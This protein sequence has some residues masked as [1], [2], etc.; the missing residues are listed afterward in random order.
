MATALLRFEQGATLGFAGEAFI[1]TAGSLV[2]VRNSNNTG[3]VS[4]TLELLYGPPGSTFEI[5]PS[6][7]AVVAS[8]SNA[9]P[10][11]TFTPQPGFPGCYRFRLTV[12]AADGSSDVDI[13]NVV[14]LTS[15]GILIPP[16]QAL[17]APLPLTGLG[18]KPDELNV[19]GQAWGWAGDEV[20]GVNRNLAILESTVGSLSRLEVTH[21]G[22]LGNEGLRA[23]VGV[24][25]GQLALVRGYNTAGDGVGA[26]LF[27]WRTTSAAND[28]GLRIVPGAAYGSNM[29]GAH[30]ERVVDGSELN[31]RWFGAAGDASWA[32]NTGGVN[33]DAGIQRA[34][35]VV[36]A[37]SAVPNS[38]PVP[39]LYFPTG[40]Y[41][42]T[43]TIQLRS[44]VSIRGDGP[45]SILFAPS[46]ASLTRVIQIGIPGSPPA[47][48]FGAVLKDISILGFATS[49]VECLAMSACDIDFYADGNFN[50]LFYSY[51]DPGLASPS[52]GDGNPS[53]AVESSVIRIRRTGFDA[54][55][56]TGWP[57][58][59]GFYVRGWVNGC[60]VYVDLTYPK[61]AGIYYESTYGSGTSRFSGL[62][63]GAGIDI[64]GNG[65]GDGY[66]A[67]IIGS[68]GIIVEN[69][70]TEGCK[71][72]V[73][74]EG[75]RETI[76]RNVQ[77]DVFCVGAIRPTIEN[78]LGYV[79][80]DDATIEPVVNNARSSNVS[81][82]PVVRATVGAVSL[83][84]SDVVGY[85][86]DLP[87]FSQLD[88]VNLVLNGDFERFTAADGQP[89]NCWGFG[90]QYLGTKCGDGCADTTR[91]ANAAH[92]LKLEFYPS[93][94][95]LAQALVLPAGS[96]SELLGTRLTVS[97]KI[98]KASANDAY[99]GIARADDLSF[100]D[101]GAASA[102]GFD[103]ENG[104]K[105]FVGSWTITQE[106]LTH[107]VLVRLSIASLTDVAYFS[108][109]QVVLGNAA[110]RGFIKPSASI[111]GSHRRVGSAIMTNANAPPATSWNGLA[112]IA[113][114]L[115]LNTG[116]SSMV[117]WRYDGD[118]WEPI[119]EIVVST[120]ADLRTLSTTGLAT[121]T[122]ARAAGYWAAGDGGGGLFRFSTSSATNNDGVVVVSGSAHGSSTSGAHW[123]RLIDSSL[124]SVRWFGARGDDAADDGTAIART[125]AAAVPLGLATF[126]PA[127]Q[128]RVT[129]S[130]DISD[131]AAATRAGTRIVGTQ[132]G[133]DGGDVSCRIIWRGPT[134]DPVI[135]AWSRGVDI[136]NISIVAITA[137]PAC[138][139]I[140]RSP[141]VG[142]NAVTN[143][144]VEQVRFECR[145]IA[146]RGIRI[147][148]LSVGNL[149]HNRF[150]DCYFDGFTVAGIDIVS[151]TGQSKGNVIQSCA[152][153]GHQASRPAA[154]KTLTGS[155]QM[156]DCQWQA[157]GTALDLGSPTDVIVVDGVDAE[158]CRRLLN[159][160]QSG[161]AWSVTVRNTR[162]SLNG[163]HPDNRVIRYRSRGPFL[164]ESV[165]FDISGPP[166]DAA[167]RIW[168]GHDDSAQPTVFT[169]RNCVFSNLTPIEIAANAIVVGQGSIGWDGTS[170][171]VSLNMN[172]D[173]RA[174]G[175]VGNG[176]VTD[177]AA[178][179]GA[180]A[181]PLVS[182][183]VV[184]PG[185][186]L[187]G[188]M[189]ISKPVRFERGA[190][191][192]IAA[193]A[194][195]TFTGTLSLPDSHCIDV[196]ASG[197]DIRL[198][199]ATP[200]VRPEWFGAVG[201]GVADDAVALRRAID[202]SV[203][204]VIGSTTGAGTWPKIPVLVSRHHRLASEIKLARYGIRI[205][206]DQ[207][208]PSFGYTFEVTK[209][210]FTIDHSGNGFRITEDGMGNPWNISVEDLIVQRSAGFSGQGSGIAFD[211][212]G[213]L[214][215][216]RFH[217]LTLWSHSRGL[218]ILASYTGG[219]VANVDLDNF[220]IAFN[221]VGVHSED[222]C[223]FNMLRIGAGVLSDNSEGGFKAPILIADI[224]GPVLA[225][226]Q[227][228]PIRITGGTTVWSRLGTIY[229]EQPGGGYDGGDALISLSAAIKVKV[230]NPAPSAGITSL[231]EVLA[232]SS[233]EIEYSGFMTAYDVA[234]SKFKGFALV[235]TG[236]DV[237]WKYFQFASWPL[238]LGPGPSMSP[239][240]IDAALETVTVFTS[241]H[242]ILTS[243]RGEEVLAATIGTSGA[244]TNLFQTNVELATW[245]PGQWLAI[246]FAIRYDEGAPL[247]AVNAQFEVFGVDPGNP[248]IATGQVYSAQYKPGTIVIWALVRNHTATTFSGAQVR[249]R[250]YG[251]TLG[252]V[253]YGALISPLVVVRLAS[254]TTR[255]PAVD[256]F[257]LMLK[258]QNPRHHDVRDF[259]A[260]VD[261]S[262]N[263]T[264]ALVSAMTRASTTK[265]PV[266]VPAG[267]MRVAGF[268]VPAGVR[269]VGEGRE[270][271]TIESTTTNVDH[272]NA[273]QGSFVTL[274]GNEC[275]LEGL[276][277]NA[278]Y[279]WAPV[280]TATG[281]FYGST[282]KDVK[283]SLSWWGEF[284]VLLGNGGGHRFERVVL[285]GCTLG[286]H[287]DST[288]APNYCQYNS[289][290]D[291]RILGG[292]LGIWLE[293]GCLGNFF[294]GVVGDF[295][296]SFAGIPGGVTMP[297]VIDTPAEMRG[298]KV[299]AG[300]PVNTAN[301]FYDCALENNGVLN[302]NVGLAI[303][304]A[305]SLAASF[306][307]SSATAGWASPPTSTSQAIHS[308]R[309]GVMR[310][311]AVVTKD[312]LIVFDGRFDGMSP[313]ASITWTP[314]DKVGTVVGTTGTW[315]WSFSGFNI[316]DKGALLQSI[317]FGVDASGGAGGFT[318]TL[319]LRGYDTLTGVETSY[320]S[321]TFSGTF[322]G[323]TVIEK[324][325]NELLK[326]NL[327]PVSFFLVVTLTKTTA[328]GL[329]L[330][331]MQ[332][333]FTTDGGV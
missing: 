63:Q 109:L 244:Q 41:R 182:E 211:G 278:R 118:S 255:F 26:G 256:P 67:R 205:R 219:E 258:H 273:N 230:E 95:G 322:V 121:G 208:P 117:G 202:A 260:K 275:G 153:V 274:N 158:D 192:K 72:A 226:S 119:S 236:N 1:V 281:N 88:G 170:A 318:G 82:S 307:N 257:D 296:D 142:A 325:L 8:G 228:N 106:M 120:V 138:I 289:I 249:Y 310:A 154:V 224:Q 233:A 151:N 171:Y 238:R 129:S 301:A 64:N 12:T 3:V 96:P 137:T 285:N 40:C 288:G 102:V 32:A 176:V 65:G 122:L 160:N 131:S 69:F 197:A 46:S 221:G 87:S 319:D 271:T 175:A 330:R 218:N 107:G 222:N 111:D 149:D 89:N 99:V 298:I 328:T 62:V 292:M 272:S 25:A 261:G 252:D 140:D 157:L 245:A 302:T 203:G 246:G 191:I 213:F 92:C 116:S 28:D 204:A 139:D 148:P 50:H 125:I 136:S 162:F 113:G 34:M 57:P 126:F 21:V 277:I 52:G 112:W 243:F 51:R 17:P 98:K 196:S 188:T 85:A 266:Y 312:N 209:P 280:L 242:T 241:G 80:L 13:R 333:A 19:N 264:D 332:V 16:Y 79:H 91:T 234:D 169:H 115:V 18:A 299:S 174:F 210:K 84:T 316:R 199:T 253:S 248:I 53:G 231:T 150:R 181:S 135:K 42:V 86:W 284:A 105:H 15:N 291:L 35:A 276:H 108:E 216:Y 97:C 290:T 83:Q 282:V 259:G 70:Y 166:F 317:S 104:F 133:A 27:I 315:W 240:E 159:V 220:A 327:L 127:G 189:T 146:E 223:R 268:T 309:F 287:L 38:V 201:D 54:Y 215:Y 75:S 5:D 49:A 24:T 217:G 200:F 251:P 326:D 193:G 73:S 93:W 183:V 239:S 90:W 61:T 297:T 225:Q 48:A 14:V 4:W 44:R 143:V 178:F 180:A 47:Y 132:G 305:S 293:D 9:N 110:P 94:G 20:T 329:A 163:L 161:S 155:F 78:V 36:L 74:L 144:K 100:A 23:R 2:T 45:S 286:M 168:V 77:E 37:R 156:R 314:T 232:I 313:D 227:P 311:L 283:L 237:Y 124:M 321:D 101:A 185:V 187:V 123:R 43:T 195:V 294:R 130:I 128:Y 262:T 229:F 308:D 167:C 190:Q 29:A 320:W 179:T 58:R 6:S 31:V 141:L 22:R 55:V 68:T 33:D 172:G 247:P 254:G 164:L 7:P 206:G 267:T 323:T 60:E 250:P 10:V 56:L 66:G 324:T 177:T 186:Y 103:C 270:R 295:A 214:I 265:L 81:K 134:T 279:A 198:N 306:Y 147:G 30:W 303:E 263:D 76:V 11:Y 207:G 145:G 300:S 184:P 173:V 39:A 304:C 331:G 165:L 212:T 114:D 152:F 59:Y 194:L 269:I 71:K 235:N